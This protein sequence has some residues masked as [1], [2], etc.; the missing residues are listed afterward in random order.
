MPV[1]P[2]RWRSAPLAAAAL[3]VC[4]L[5]LAP[6][7]A[8][9]QDESSPSINL[10]SSRIGG[11]GLTQ[12]ERRR[13][14][15]WDEPEEFVTEQTLPAVGHKKRLPS[16]HVLA[17]RYVGGQ[18]WKEACRFYDMIRAEHGDEGLDAKPDARS[19]AARA[20]LGCAEAAFH[21]DALDDVETR[22]QLAEKLGLRSGRIEFLRRKVL[23]DRFRA[24]LGAGDLMGARQLYDTFQK[25]GEPDEDER[26]WFGEQ[27]AAQA[28]AA[29]EM[30]DKVAYKE[31]MEILEEVSPM[32]TDYRALRAEE[33]GGE[34]VMKNI[35]MVLGVALGAIVLLTLLSK[36]R[37]RPR[38]EGGA[39]RGKN[40]YLDDDDL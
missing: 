31:A 28:K 29:K 22:L 1:Q 36:W 34:E 15:S 30:K 32:N 7:S 19:T 6:E 39:S 12:R 3:L 18:Q 26:I 27:L 24:K 4:P 37:S 20:Y 5:L 16:L 40:P 21:E 17:E 38:L 10:G 25:A 11:P 35:I 23:R 2:S 33:S 13:V 9:A 8:Q 14:E